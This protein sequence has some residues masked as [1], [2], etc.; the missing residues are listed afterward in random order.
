MD[1]T[2]DSQGGWVVHGERTLY[3][4]SWVPPAKTRSLIAEGRVQSSGTLVAR[5]P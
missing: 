2:E 5:E 3:D 1:R 4:N